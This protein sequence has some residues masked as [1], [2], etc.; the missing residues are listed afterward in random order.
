MKA[1]DV[2]VGPAG[3]LAVA[4]DRMQPLFA[5]GTRLWVAWVFLKSGWLKA[6][7]WDST[8]F[9]FEEEYRVPLM[10]P[11]VAAWAATAAEI[12]FPVLLVLGLAGRIGAIGLFAVNALAVFSYRHVLLTDGF[13]AA[14][15]QHYLWGFAL[16]YLCVYGC[17][18]LSLDSLLPGRSASGGATATRTDPQA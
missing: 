16:A 10:S 8:L 2:V 6:L 11:Q 18:P 3:S 17:G 4:L 15:G 7:D 12:A 14:A 9:L 5:L 13:E 1:M